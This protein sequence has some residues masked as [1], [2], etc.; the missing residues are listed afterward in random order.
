MESIIG[1]AVG[2]H[3]VL[4]IDKEGSL[5]GLGSN[6]SGQFGNGS[7]VYETFRSTPEKLINK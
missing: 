5:W 2:Q 6:R 1:A 4:F 7:N 3:N